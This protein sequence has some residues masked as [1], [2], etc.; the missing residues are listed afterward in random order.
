MHET[1]TPSSAVI[2]LL[3]EGRKIDAIKLV[4]EE[5]NLGLKEA[6]H[7]IEDY[8]L[9]NPARFPLINQPTSANQLMIY[10]RLVLA[11]VLTYQ[12]MTS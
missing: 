3:N 8:V 10:A 2:A 6:K 5:K 11:I 12:Y 1:E 9:K 4:R 7:F